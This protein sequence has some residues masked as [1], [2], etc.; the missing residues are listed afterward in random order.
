MAVPT[1]SLQKENSS[2]RDGAPHGMRCRATRNYTAAQSLRERARI[3]PQGWLTVFS[4]S[5]WGLSGCAAQANDEFLVMSDLCRMFVPFWYQIIQ[6]CIWLFLL[7]KC[8][9]LSLGIYFFSLFSKEIL[10]CFSEARF[11]IP[12][13]F[14]S[15]AHYC[16]WCYR[17]GEKKAN[18]KNRH[19]SHA[20]NN[21]IQWFFFFF[22][23]SRKQLS[24]HLPHF[25]AHPL[26]CFATFPSPA[27]ASVMLGCHVCPGW[28]LSH[29]MCLSFKTHTGFLISMF[30]LP[31]TVP[32]KSVEWTRDGIMCFYT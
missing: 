4:L 9:L 29:Q 15:C 18:F 8:V 22:F 13:V 17:A 21:Y 10:N 19:E 25:R 23:T 16:H 14:F 5:V 1:E 32:H 30:S 28:S 26:S 24:C 3:A 31:R 6:G 2:S 7:I 27:V 20:M 12:P 11:S